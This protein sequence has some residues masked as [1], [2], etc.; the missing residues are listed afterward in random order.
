V[1]LETTIPDA[2][3]GAS[4]ASASLAIRWVF[5]ASDGSITQLVVG[6]TMFGRDASCAGYLPSGS[7]S[8]THAA[9]RW[10]PG[11]VPMLRDL[12]STNG[13][14]VNGLRV[15]QAPLKPRDVLRIGDFIGVLVVFPAEDPTA[16]TFQEVA[17]GYWAGPALLA[18]LEPARLVA[19][20]DLPIIIQGET[21]AGKEG[22]AHAIAAWSG[23]KGPFMAVNCAALPEALAEGELFGYRRGA[24]SGADRAHPGFLRAAQGGTLLLDEIADLTLPIQA[25]LLRAVEQRE[26]VPLGESEPVAIDVRLLAAAQSPLRQAVDEKRFRGDLLARL[27]GLTVRLPALRERVEEVPYLFA[28]LVEQHSGAAAPPRLDPLLVESLCAHDWPFNVRE[29]ALLVRRLLALHPKAAV[30]DHGM[31]SAKVRPED[32]L[33]AP[34]SVASR[35]PIDPASTEASQDE[36]PDPD[37][38]ELLSA[39][40]VERGNVKRTAITLGISR[41][42]LYRLMEKLGS[43]DL[44]AIRQSEKSDGTSERLP[45]P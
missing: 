24:F 28:R 26:V 11:G 42:R 9:I 5:P 37:P 22:A 31:L 44:A 30:L 13:V 38:G 34:P 15:R 21:G 40:R 16:W 41:G 43:L 14:F 17:K 10:V 1:A 18:A 3:V 4:N 23:R 27:D 32:N 39:L 29:L 2:V 12:D 33:G 35:P 25:K 6:Q 19:T 8:R 36:T 7:V 45:R 20:T